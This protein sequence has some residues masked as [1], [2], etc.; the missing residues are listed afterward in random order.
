MPDHELNP[1]DAKLVEWLQ[2]AHAKE[3]ELET[4]LERHISVTDKMAYKKRL[5]SHLTETR[6]HA[7]RI[8]TRIHQIGGSVD[9]PSITKPAIDVAQKT[10]QTVKG[11][12][13]ALRAAA[14]DQAETHL[15]NVQDE[16]RE[17]HVEIALYDRIEAF[18]LEVGDVDTAK[19]AASI[20]RDEARMAKYLE[21]EL[22]RLVKDVV[23]A[24]V[25]LEYRRRPRP[26]GAAR[27]RQ[28]TR[29]GNQRR[30]GTTARSR[31]R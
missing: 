23:R 28:S 17:E 14:S 1:R 25:P 22:P 19:L 3:S 26:R 21:S 16:L 2:E 12:V 13:G 7:R 27:S 29:R 9:G 30:T 10:L 6:D 24:E 18:A 11:G 8:A 5:R 31:G 15:R 20:R 4:V